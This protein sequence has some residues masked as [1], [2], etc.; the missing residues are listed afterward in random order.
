MNINSLYLGIARQT[1]TNG[2]IKMKSK[3]K[4]QRALEAFGSVVNGVIVGGLAYVILTV[5]LLWEGGCN[6]ALLIAVCVGVL[7]CLS[8][9]DEP[10]NK[11]L[12]D[13]VK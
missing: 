3:D 13:E 1:A 11:L 6:P 12:G 10:L 5:L 7:V 9:Y 8:W 4:T 2:D